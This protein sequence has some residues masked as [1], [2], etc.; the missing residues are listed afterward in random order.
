VSKL[1]ILSFV[2]IFSIVCAQPASAL[3]GSECRKPKASYENYKKEAQRFKTLSISQELA[4]KEKLK[5]AI[6]TCNADFKSYAYA[7]KRTNVIKKKSDCGMLP[8]FNEFLIVPAT[9]ESM[10]ASE[11]AYRVVINNQKCF[12]PELVIEAQRALKMIK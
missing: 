9:Y 11:N 4:N 8:L 2:I 7:T 10:T 1:K 5:K 6:A 3:F 12:S